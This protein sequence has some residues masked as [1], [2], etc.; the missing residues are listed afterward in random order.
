VHRAD[1]RYRL[2]GIDAA[3]IHY[4]QCEAERRLGVLTK[5][6]LDDLLRSGLVTIHPDPPAKRD[7][8]RRLL[9]HLFVNG[10]DVGCILIREGYAQPWRGRREDWCVK[11]DFK[12]A[13]LDVDSA[14]GAI[15]AR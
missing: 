15:D 3:E 1:E 9:V 6:R 10:E 2:A 5:R 7:K 4:A 11:T 8:Y 13:D 14:T 12:R